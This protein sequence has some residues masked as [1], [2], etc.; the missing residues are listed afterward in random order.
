MPT[1]LTALVN[2]GRYASLAGL[3]RVSRPRLSAGFD[4]A[5]DAGACRIADELALVQTV[6]FLTPIVGD[7]HNFGAMAAANALSGV[8][9]MG[10]TPLTA[11]S[12]LISLAQPALERGLKLTLIP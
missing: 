7:T 2:A 6:D 1:T 5:D 3:P 12:S 11:L 9:A 10:G 8:W 4:T